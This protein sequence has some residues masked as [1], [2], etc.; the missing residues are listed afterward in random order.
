MLKKVESGIFFI[1]GATLIS[2]LNGAL[3]KIL[4]E[5][6][7]ALEIVFLRNLIGI[8]IILY[9]LKHTAPKLTGGKFHMLF[10]R[11][12]FGFMAM[13][14][15]FYTI[16]VIPLGEAMTMNKTSPFF[17]TLLA[18][19]ILH[20]HLSKRTLFA[21][22]I[23]FLGVVF[24]ARPFG[25]S[26]SYA[27]FLGILGGFFAAAAYTTIKK[28]KDIYDSRVIVL[29]FVV[30]GTLLPA[31]LFL[32]APLMDVPAPLRF[33]FPE[34]IMPGSLHVWLLIVLM[35]FI[36]TLSQWLLT[37]AYSASNL[38]IIGV[39][40]YAN[41]P[42]GIGFGYMLGDSFPDTLTFTGILLIIFGGILV[43]KK[44]S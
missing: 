3:T 29:S 20:E 10:V 2:A 35:A 40:S 8:F 43:S 37:K 17:V 14:L 22:L 27:H 15:F 19:F 6:I 21:L 11:G 28:I 25:M 42:F 5:D 39:V 36:S 41:I 38:S 16:A 44:R 34:F 24:I 32:S 9:T 12:L 1:L 30:V 33:L 4:T 23:G 26:F 7:S 31:L 18:Y 13:I